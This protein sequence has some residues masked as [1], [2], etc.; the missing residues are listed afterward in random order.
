MT[1][2]R[3]QRE[4]KELQTRLDELTVPRDE[5]GRGIRSAAQGPRARDSRARAARVPRAQHEDLME[6]GS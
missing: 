4:R 1:L 3:V 2:A 6:A 5:L